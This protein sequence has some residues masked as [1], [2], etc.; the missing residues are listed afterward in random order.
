MTSTSLIEQF[1]AAL[2]RNRLEPLFGRDVPRELRTKEL[3]DVPDMYEWEI[4]PAADNAW[5][6]PL[7]SGLP[8]PF[9]TIYRSLIS[10]FRFAEF[11]VGPVMFL[12]NTG[13]NDV[14]H[15][16]SRVWADDPFPNELLRHGF[17]QFG[18]QAGGGYDPVCFAMKQRK[19]G[20]APLV[21]LDHEEVLIRNRI[22]IQVEI[23]PSFG[24]F[25]QG[26]VAGEIG[27]RK[28]R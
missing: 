24:A 3:K 16:L 10:H 17:L 2:N 18:R 1:V 22:R 6:G 9:P 14:F 20:D 12:A 19:K 13:R 23:A 7:E 27:L 25:V 21:Q 4:R 28:K 8:Y 26:V 11:E 15:E 5:V